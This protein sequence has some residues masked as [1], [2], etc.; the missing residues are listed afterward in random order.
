[1][2]PPPSKQPSS[3]W[4]NADPG[5]AVVLGAT[6]GIGRAFVEQL[7]AGGHELVIVARNRH[8]LEELAQ[9]VRARHG[10][11][12]EVLAADLAVDADLRRVEDRLRED[13]GLQLLV[14]AAGLASWGRFWELDVERELDII[15]VNV[16]A[17]MRLT[18]AALATMLPRRQGAIVN[19]ASLAGYMM[20][21]FCAT[22]GGTKAYLVSFTEALYEELRGTGVRIQVVC[23][24]FTQTDMFTRSGAN[25]AKMPGFIWGR[26]ETIARSSLAALHRDRPVCIPDIRFRVLAVLLR[27]TPRSVVRR[28]TSRLF[29]NFNIYRL[30]GP[31]SSSGEPRG[32]T[33][34]PSPTAKEAPG[35]RG[36]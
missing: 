5:R 10:G 17:G 33:A 7:A 21:P 32:P 27:L 28:L 2:S 29:G 26:P 4:P 20:L 14:N 23:P 16:I 22:Y 11:A 34:V 12:V 36:Q 30:D 13:A 1:M 24:G 19:V 31:D 3:L 8:R 18:K 35:P 6:G 15:R 9:Q 25:T